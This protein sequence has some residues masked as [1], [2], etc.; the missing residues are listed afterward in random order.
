VFVGGW[1]LSAAEAVCTGD[2]ITAHEIIGLLQRLVDKSLVI[3]DPHAHERHFGLLETIRQYAHDRLVEA[4]ESDRVQNGQAS[5]YLQFAEEAS[6]NL[7][8]AAQA[9]WLRRLD[10]EYSNLRTA[11]A[12]FETSRQTKQGLRLAVAL[13]YY[14]Y[15]RLYMTDGRRWLERFLV[16]HKGRGENPTPVQAKAVL[17]LSELDRLQGD[18]VAA[19]AHAEESHGL[20]A[21]LSDQVGLAESFRA[22][23]GIALAERRYPAARLLLEKSLAL[24][25]DSGDAHLRAWTLNGLGEAA[26][27]QNDGALAEGFYLKALELY[28]STGD[29]FRI[30]SLLLNLGFLALQ[31]GHPA[32]ARTWLHE[33]LTICRKVND[34]GNIEGCLIGLAG[35]LG[36]TGDSDRAVKILGAV[37]AAMTANGMPLDSPDQIVYDNILVQLHAQLN[38]ATFTATWSAGQQLTIEQAIDLALSETS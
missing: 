13:S 7:F 11:L 12:W 33:S 5:Y 26:R 37:D 24:Q 25:G 3:T 22:L 30:S 35:V 14:W 36:A 10:R 29:E 31:Q 19:Q 28:R 6:Q 15:I 20:F 38:D 27:A 4:G 32:E 17:W 8:G 1:T 18:Y 9:A 21:D 23:S 2:G 16:A 34:M